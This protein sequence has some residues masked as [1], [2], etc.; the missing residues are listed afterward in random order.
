[1]NTIIMRPFNEVFPL[2]AIAH[3]FAGQDDAKGVYAKE[4]HIPARMTMVSHKH[5][6]DHIS[7]LAS[8]TV[9]LQINGLT[10]MR[11]GPCAIV[12]R[13]GEEHSL[14]AITDAVWFCVHPTE[15]TDVLKV[16]DAILAK[17]SV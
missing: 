17:E 12:I 13:K 8:G 9:Q 5:E 4:I 11:T 15:E 10:N 16:D 3:H 14:Y 6:Y 1:M 2:E 7:I